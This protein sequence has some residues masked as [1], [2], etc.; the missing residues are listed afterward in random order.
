M[1]YDQLLGHL[2]E[3]SADGP[4]KVFCCGT[5]FLLVSKAYLCLTVTCGDKT[6]LRKFASTWARKELCSYFLGRMPANTKLWSIRIVPLS[7]TTHTLALE[8]VHP[9]HVHSE[10]LASL[11]P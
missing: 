10:V 7:S 6:S 9:H 4:V 1:I 5:R 3:I 8:E 2:Q 11:Q